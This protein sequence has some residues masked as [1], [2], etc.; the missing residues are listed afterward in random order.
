MDKRTPFPYVFWVANTVEVLERFAYY[1]IYLGFGIK[2]RSILGERPGWQPY[3]LSS[4]LP[5]RPIL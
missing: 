3:G 4:R 2:P 5:R 1:G